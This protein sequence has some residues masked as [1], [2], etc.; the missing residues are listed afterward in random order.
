MAAKSGRYGGKSLIFGIGEIKMNKVKEILR[1]I[2]PDSYGNY[3]YCHYGLRQVMGMLYD[4]ADGTSKDEL[5]DWK[6]EDQ[7]IQSNETLLSGNLLMINR[8]N[9]VKI[10]PEYDKKLQIKYSAKSLFYNDNNRKNI[11]T[12]AND[13]VKEH[14][15]G[16]IKNAVSEGNLKGVAAIVTNSVYFYS[17]W[18]EKLEEAGNIL[19][20][21]TQNNE[22]EVV[23]V[24]GKTNKYISN[25]KVH[26]FSYAYSDKR[27]SFIA[28]ML[29]NEDKKFSW[30]DIPNLEKFEETEDK[31]SISNNGKITESGS[32]KINKK[33]VHFTMPKF[34]VDAEVNFDEAL[35]A[36]GIKSIYGTNANLS[37]GFSC[38]NGLYLSTINQKSGIVVDEN[39]TEAWSFSSGAAIC[40]MMIEPVQLT[41]NKP[42]FFMVYDKVDEQ[43]VFAGIINNPQWQ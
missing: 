4:A 21:L 15:G 3:F 40:K 8:N 35:K 30:Q 43:S 17:K 31:G 1:N 19:F 23:A 27:Y 34:K 16:H 9:G 2:E 18:S 7:F 28:L 29:K 14:T 13:F 41:F 36:L 26:G 20:S 38:Y 37:K 22:K 33:E 39:G 12:E 42:Y 10:N 24:K 11:I 5:A 6:I 25:E 32:T